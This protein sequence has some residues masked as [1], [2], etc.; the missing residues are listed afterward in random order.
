VISV[1][2][3][4][5]PRSASPISGGPFDIDNRQS[6][7]ER[8]EERALDPAFWETPDNARAVL[9]E[10]AAQKQVLDRFAGVLGEVEDLIELLEVSGED[11][12]EDLNQIADG[13][14]QQVDSLELETMLC[15]SD[16]TRNAI[17]TVHPG[18]GGTESEDW[19]GMLVRMYRAFCDQ[20]GWKVTM[21]D[22][23][24]GEQT[25]FKNA[26][27]EVSGTH[28]Y[29]RLRSE[30]GVH[31]LVRISPFDSQSRRHTSFASVFLYP[32]VEE[33][34]DVDIEIDPSDL[35]VDTFRASG[36]G[37]QHVNKTDSAIRI[38]HLPSGI[39][40]QCQNERSQSRNR[41]TAMKLLKA[42]LLAKKREEDDARIAKLEGS[43]M[44]NAWGSQIRSY[45]LHPYNMVKDHRTSVETSDTNGVLGGRLDQFIKGYLLDPDLN[46]ASKSP[47]R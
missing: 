41:A 13:I 11:E 5:P 35:R 21:I 2:Y 20:Q 37:G 30:V 10:T 46:R 44:E 23:Q 47:R 14:T 28:V 40:T 22:E 32:V 25:G 16:D 39:V 43:K 27:M 24:P 9:K 45:V 8:L 17:L 38:T 15:G 42:R 33:V 29:G 26:S 18:A 3:V 31:R 4:K 19:A 36:A 7:L 34:D 12:L 1:V 6:A